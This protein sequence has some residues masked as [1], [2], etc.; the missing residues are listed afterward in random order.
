MRSFASTSFDAVVCKMRK[1]CLLFALSIT[2]N[3]RFRS[4]AALYLQMLLLG[5]VHSKK[6]HALIIKH[7]V[8][9]KEKLGGGAILKGFEVQGRAI[10]W[11]YYFLKSAE[12]SVSVLKN[13][14]N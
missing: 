8:I 7:A 13:V 6:K 12:L 1:N 4:R 5:N 2:E 9:S 14:Q 10:T 11:V 3:E